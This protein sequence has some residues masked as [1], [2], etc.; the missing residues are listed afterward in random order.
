MVVT[1]RSQK[2]FSNHQPTKKS[3]KDNIETIINLN[4]DCPAF[5]N[6]IMLL[7]LEYTYLQ[8]VTV[9]EAEGTFYSVFI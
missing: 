6:K 7:V 8:Y 1:E 9:S 5:L 3:D 2:L 4:N